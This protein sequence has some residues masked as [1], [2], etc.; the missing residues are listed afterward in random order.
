MSRWRQSSDPGSNE[1]WGDGGK[2][3]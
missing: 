2:V 1:P 3:R